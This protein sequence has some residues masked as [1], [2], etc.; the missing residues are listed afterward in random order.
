MKSELN[1]SQPEDGHLQALQHGANFLVLPDAPSGAASFRATLYWRS[2]VHSTAS[3]SAKVEPSSPKLRPVP[4]AQNGAL[5]KV[6]QAIAA[7]PSSAPG[8]LN[9]MSN[10]CH[11]QPKFL[12]RIRLRV[13]FRSRNCALL[14]CRVR[15]LYADT[16]EDRCVE[17][18]GVPHHPHGRRQ[19]NAL[20]VDE[21]ESMERGYG[22]G[23]VRVIGHAG[24]A[25]PLRDH[26]NRA[27]PHV[28]VGT[29]HAR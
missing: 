8:R 28:R 23:L 2:F 21:P 4:G 9:T 6:P 26:C 16:A 14:R 27:R 12:L 3:K 5:D 7:W 19:H 25:G 29:R 10:S 22:E 17:G 20:T 11:V 1:F 13:M 18:S 24:R 15:P